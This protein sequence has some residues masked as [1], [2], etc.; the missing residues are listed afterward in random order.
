M[1]PMSSADMESSRTPEPRLAMTW[2]LTWLIVIALVGCVVCAASFAL[3]LPVVGFTVCAISSLLLSGVVLLRIPSRQLW[4]EKLEV[5]SSIGVL[6]GNVMLSVLLGALLFQLS[7]RRSSVLYGCL[8]VLSIVVDV[9]IAIAL[10]ALRMRRS[11]VPSIAVVTVACVAG[12][13]MLCLAP[14][15]AK[16]LPSW[17]RAVVNVHPSC[18]TVAPLY[19]GEAAWNVLDV[20]TWCGEATLVASDGPRSPALDVWQFVSSADHARV[21]AVG[22]SVPQAPLRSTV[23]APD[24]VRLELYCNGVLRWPRYSTAFGVTDDPEGVCHGRGDD[25]W[26]TGTADETLLL[27]P[28]FVAA[29]SIFG[30]A[31]VGG[32]GLVVMCACRRRYDHA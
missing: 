3:A 10:R 18:L 32:S 2:A 22:N 21:L 9:G 11:L 24:A 7:D 17:R 27:E 4:F 14:R 19:D 6:A 25:A 30:A 28:G 15:F 16:Q 13:V 26:F 29:V 5:D 23:I 31:L 20:P 12:V 8:S 1:T